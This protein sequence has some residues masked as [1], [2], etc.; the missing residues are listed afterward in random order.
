MNNKK[1]EFNFK[2]NLNVTCEQVRIVN[3]NE[4]TDTEIAD[5]ISKYNAIGLARKYNTDLIEISV[6]NKDNVSICKL[7][8]EDKYIYQLKKAAKERNKNNKKHELKEIRLRPNIDTGDLETKMKAV[9]KFLNDGDTVKL[10]MFFRGRELLLYKDVAE[11][12]ILEIVDKLSDIC[13]VREMPKL[14]G[15]RMT[16]TIFPKK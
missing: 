13:K 15:K 2:T 14:E 4:F 16:I 5:V 3:K 6:N 1:T 9:E 12:K 10:S 11:V 8:P 7:I